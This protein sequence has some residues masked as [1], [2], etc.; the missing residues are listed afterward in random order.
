MGWKGFQP[1]FLQDLHNIQTINGY[2]SKRA[3]HSLV[4]CKHNSSS[5][6]CTSFPVLEI[7]VVSDYHC[8]HSPVLIPV[9][10]ASYK[11]PKTVNVALV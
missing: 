5:L 4:S 3:I 2:L 8:V 11:T 7:E 1:R 9:C 10:K 6:I